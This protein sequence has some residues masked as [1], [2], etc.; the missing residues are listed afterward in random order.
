[1]PTTKIR[2]DA[3]GLY[4]RTDGQI[5][6]PVRTPYGYTISHARNSR[7]D[8]SSAFQE[9]DEVKAQH[10]SQT[11][12]ATVA[13]GDVL[14]WWHGHGEYIGKKSDECWTPVTEG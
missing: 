10:R 14:E 8:G 6:R 11:P 1:M 7:E 2:K 4:V 12:F 5:F 9:G 3:H 13:K